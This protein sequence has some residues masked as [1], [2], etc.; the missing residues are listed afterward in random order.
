MG[1]LPAVIRSCYLALLRILHSELALFMQTNA[2]PFGC[3][4]RLQ[5]SQL[6]NPSSSIHKSHYSV[7]FCIHHTVFNHPLS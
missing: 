6:N 1:R 7:L 5:C 2:E 4:S 3:L